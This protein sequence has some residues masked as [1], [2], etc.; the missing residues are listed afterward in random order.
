MRIIAALVLSSAIVSACG[1]ATQP[2]PA[3]QQA[4]PAKETAR[5]NAYLD[6]EYEKELAMSPTSLTMQGRK[7]QYDSLDD[8][9]DANEQRLLEWRRTSVAGMKSA[10]SYD[11]LDDEGKTSFDIWAQ[12]LD[13]AERNRRYTDHAY[14]FINGGSHV[15]LP[16]FLINFHR[17]DDPQDMDAYI[18]RLG[19][20]GRAIDQLIARA[21]GASAKGIRPPRFAFEQALRE[22]RNIITGA[23][24]G[25]GADSALFADARSK[26]A[27]LEKAGKINAAAAAALTTRVRSV[28]V[29]DVRPA[30][31]RLVAWLE[32]DARNTP[33]EPQG[34]SVLPDG[35][36]FYDASLAQQTTTSMT[37][38]EIHALGL[39]EVARI[40]GEMEA[41]KARVGF[42]GTLPAFFASMR[43]NRRFFLPN[44]DDGR[45][46][47]LAMAEQ[48]LG[49]M[50]KKLPDYFGIL[51]KAPLVVKRVEAFREEA[52][53]AQH[54]FAGTPD[55]SRPGIFYAHLS[56]MNAMPTYQLE[57]IA[58]HEG[59]PGHHM[60][61]SIAQERT[62]LPKFRTQYF[63]GAYAEGWGLYA[64]ALAK[65]MG[66]F[67]DPYS[68]MGRLSGEMWRAIR[69][70][71]DTGIHAKGWT[72]Q[73]SVDYFLANSPMAEGAV[74]SEVRRYFV[75]PGQATTYKI[76]MLTLQ[77]LRDDARGNLGTRFDYRAFHD[78]VLGGGSLPL[79]VL[80]GRVRRWQA[81]VLQPRESSGR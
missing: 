33:A 38:D 80:E 16:Q 79:P 32:T 75:W 54:Y 5:L 71:V 61:V 6:A 64:E 59:V 52:G 44:T 10:F 53:G 65:E 37:S 11:S 14:I 67:T 70:V 2:G 43:N 56:D 78:V 29:S 50:E 28:L 23:P 41:V 20:V 31:E 40:R 27:A 17:V 51:P 25:P 1:Q 73:Q 39:S 58:Y 22:S 4:D 77:R 46:A 47:Y 30:Y 15:S 7:E 74:R 62:G 18:A 8:F 68:E 24:F 72:E 36:A 26:V 34:V 45:K 9:S 81:T 21:Q 63:Y 69:L 13:R 19:Q 48:F 35:R 57:D 60:Q 42:T 12:E 3:A 66:F 55:G 49:A 76:G